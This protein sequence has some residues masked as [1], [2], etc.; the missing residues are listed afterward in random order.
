MLK[1]LAARLPSGMQV[2]LKRVHFQRQIRLNR[3]T[4]DEP[5]YFQ[6]HNYIKSGDTVIDVGANVGHYT[7]RMAE[8]VGPSGHVVAIEPIRQTFEILL[9]NIGNQTQVY[10]VAAAASDR[11]GWLHMDIPEVGGVKNLYRSS[12]VPGGKHSV[13][14][15][16]IDALEL[17][18][19][20]LIKIDA[21]GHE[22]EVLKGAE[23]LIRRCKPVLIVETPPKGI[24][25]NW[26]ETLDYSY[27]RA[28][29]SPN[30]FARIIRAT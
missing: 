4:A 20:A 23:Q 2:T 28:Y 21:E 26:L 15:M 1:S 16:T 12:V 7:R 11:K 13:R 27:T 17:D 14:S 5:E 24:A 19:V 10:P 9:S 3:F 18:S 30:L 22:M 6:L 25:A 29:N 8:L